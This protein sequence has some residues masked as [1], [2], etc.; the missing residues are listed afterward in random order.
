[1]KAEPSP[2]RI[3]ALLLRRMRRHLPLPSST[4]E[5][6]SVRVDAGG[7]ERAVLPPALTR[8]T[9]PLPCSRW[10]NKDQD[11]I[12]FARHQCHRS[13]DHGRNALTRRAGRPVMLK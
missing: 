7:G 12:R 13:P 6:R 9:S 3:W 1:M 11:P 5:A 4:G 8:L 10:V 2:L